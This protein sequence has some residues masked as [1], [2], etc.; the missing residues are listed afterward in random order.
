LSIPKILSTNAGLD[1]QD[2]IVKVQDAMQE[3]NKPYGIDLNSGEPI[4]PQDIGVFDNYCVKRQL[5]HNAPV[6]ASQ[7][8]Q[9]DTIMRAGMATV[10]P[11]ANAE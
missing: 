7:L 11:K 4:L 9:I 5:L 1:C 6:L 3:H 2:S 10:K 8:L